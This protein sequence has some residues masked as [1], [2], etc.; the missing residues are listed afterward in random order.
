MVGKFKG[1]DGTWKYDYTVF[2]KWVEF[3]FSCG[4]TEQIDCYSIL[5]WHLTYEYFD[6]ALNVSVSKQNQ[7]GIRNPRAHA[8]Q[9][10]KCMDGLL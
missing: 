10:L 2:D 6:A 3:M 5:P 4:I 8:L 7:L 1:L 9:Y